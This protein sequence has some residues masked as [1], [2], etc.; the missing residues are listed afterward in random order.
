MISETIR[1]LTGKGS[2]ALAWD[3]IFKYFNSTHQKGETGYVQGEKIAVKIN[4]N[5]ADDH[6]EMDGA[7]NISPQMVLGLLRQL[8]S[9]ANV[10]AAN[11]TFYDV[12]RHIPSTIFDLCKQEYPDVNFVDKDGGDGRIKGEPDTG[13]P[14]SWSQVPDLEPLANPAFTAYLPTCVTEADYIVNFGNLKAHSLAG[15]SICAKNM[16]GSFFAPNTSGLQ[17]PQAAGIHPYIAA[18]TSDGYDMR[19][20]ASYNSLVDLMGDRD[21]GGKTLL[22]LVD[23]LFAATSQGVTLDYRC[24]WESAPFNGNWTSSLFASLDMV[25]IESVCLDFLRAEQAVSD[26][27]GN[28]TGNIDNFLHEAAQANNPP[29]G[30]FYHPGSN[31]R[32]ESLGV[33]EHWNNA[34]D[35]KYTRTL[36]TGEGIELVPIIHVWGSTSI[37]PPVL[38]DDI[39]VYPNPAYDYIRIRFPEQPTVNRNIEIYNFN[40]VLLYTE[41]LTSGLYGNIH[42]VNVS[43]FKGPLVL[44]I[45]TGNNTYSKIVFRRPC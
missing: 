36:G 17:P 34:Q 26:E 23:G 10:P 27:M 7:T 20:M 44:K 22:F 42:E 4:L 6:G 43:E 8:V 15:M 41:L 19:P 40:G 35:K 3:G 28:V 18:R 25:A 45:S 2:D 21:L 31:E 38:G 37:D 5:N 12:S 24:K 1:Q 30:T 16:L 11:I 32:L 39:E 14:I 13:H 9:E 33:H 29:S